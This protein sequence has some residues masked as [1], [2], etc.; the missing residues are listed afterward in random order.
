M[1]G[2]FKRRD[3]DPGVSVIV[4]GHWSLVSSWEQVSGFAR[5]FEMAAGKTGAVAVFTVPVPRGTGTSG[6]FVMSSAE[7]YL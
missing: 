5:E 4:I 7:R 2:A 1:A 6:T 3:Q